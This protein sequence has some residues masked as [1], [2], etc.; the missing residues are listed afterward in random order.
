M[1]SILWKGMFL[2]PAFGRWGFFLSEP[3]VP[4]NVRWCGGDVIRWPSAA[5]P[6][7]RQVKIL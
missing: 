5:M 7:P 2:A 1:P 6:D 4:L 3:S